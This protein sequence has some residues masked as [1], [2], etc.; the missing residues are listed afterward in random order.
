[1]ICGAFSE[2]GQLFP[3]GKV[4]YHAPGRAAGDGGYRAATDVMLSV[5]GVFA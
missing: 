3:F 2:T 1:M 5:P 4:M